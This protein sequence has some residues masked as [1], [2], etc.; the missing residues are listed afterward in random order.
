[1]LTANFLQ[2]ADTIKAEKLTFMSMS[3]VMRAFN[4]TTGNLPALLQTFSDVEKLR[5]INPIGVL[6]IEIDHTF[7]TQHAQTT[8]KQALAVLELLQSELPLEF[9]WLT[10]AKTITNCNQLFF[11]LRKPE[12]YIS[13]IDKTIQDARLTL[14]KIR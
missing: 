4:G 9:T 8:H 5:S 13:T 1:M 3:K 10:H 6:N 14:L 2:T 7:L 12:Y 11:A